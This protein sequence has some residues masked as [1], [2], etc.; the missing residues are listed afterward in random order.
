MSAREKLQMETTS[1]PHARRISCKRCQKRKIKCTRTYPCSSCS[2]ANVRCEFREDDFKRP[3]VSREYIAALESRVATLEAVIGRLKGASYE[4]RDEILEGV[5]LQEHTQSF[6]P[7]TAADTDVDE[8]ALSDA[9]RKATL[10]ETDEGTPTTHMKPPSFPP[11]S[12][13]HLT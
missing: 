12:R 11:K 2:A 7:E 10:H 8:I 3:P 1:A 5:T 13:K 9:I 6:A 4:E